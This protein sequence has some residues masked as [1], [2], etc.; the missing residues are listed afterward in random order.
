[1]VNTKKNSVI[2]SYFLETKR[3]T[4]KEALTSHCSSTKETDTSE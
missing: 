3:Q 1:M 2:L 4:V